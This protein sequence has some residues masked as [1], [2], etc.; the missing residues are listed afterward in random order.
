MIKLLRSIYSLVHDEELRA[1]IASDL[2]WRVLDDEEGIKDLAVDTLDDL[3]LRGR[4]SRG[5]GT[6]D[7]AN[8]L[9]AVIIKSGERQP[10]MADFIKALIARHA[11]KGTKPA[12]H[13]LQGVAD[14]LID[15]L[16]EGYEDATS[17]LVGY[18]KTVHVLLTAS[19]TGLSVG[20]AATL[21]PFLKSAT[22]AEEQLVSEFVLRIFN[23]T[24]PSMPKSS[25]KFARD[26]QAVLLPM[27]NKPS[28]LGGLSVRNKLGAV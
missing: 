1:G 27:L 8:V 12:L 6:A 13:Q 19:P 2:I 28:P 10:P 18:I 21:L 23:V 24:L 14:I 17:H 26:L 15:R 5:D 4:S 25:S 9:V 16:A 3:W 7:L 22:N 11:E 20:K